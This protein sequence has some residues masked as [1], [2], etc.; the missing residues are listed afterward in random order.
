M[1][2]KRRSRAAD[3]AVYLL[4]RVAVCFVQ[5]LSWPRALWLARGLAWLLY[6]VD[7]RH[8]LVAADNLRHAFPD[9]DAPA[10]D[11]VVRASY[12]HLTTMLVEM[13]RLPRVLCRANLY[14]Y[15]SHARPDD[16]AR[17]LAA[18]RGG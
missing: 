1:S 7:R 17:M 10:A 2:A 9:L 4:V 13:M 5:A 11:R 6:R 8:R 18:K 15:V 16:L 14:D 3:F 12:L